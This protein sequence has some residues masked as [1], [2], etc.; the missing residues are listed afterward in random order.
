MVCANLEFRLLVLPRH[1]VG[2]GVLYK[3]AEVKGGVFKL[4]KYVD[5]THFRWSLESVFFTGYF[6]GPCSKH[7]D[8]IWDEHRRLGGES[9]REIVSFRFVH[10]C[11]R[12]RDLV[13]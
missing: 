2:K 3:I 9:S 12:A 13:P 5:L 10:A 8:F 11:V 6:Q 4:Q 1:E 7:H